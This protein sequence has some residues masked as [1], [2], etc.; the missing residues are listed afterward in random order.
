[1]KPHHRKCKEAKFLSGFDQLLLEKERCIYVFKAKF[2][3]V[4]VVVYALI[5]SDKLIRKSSSTIFCKPIP[6][7]ASK[8]F[9][10]RRLFSS[11]AR[12][13]VYVAFHA[14]VDRSIRIVIPA[15]MRAPLCDGRRPIKLIHTVMMTLAG[16]STAP[17]ITWIK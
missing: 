6:N 2:L 9:P 10:R 17:K 8:L 12:T 11:D 5:K 14:T 7:L 1:M 16:M 15:T 3:W 13:A 4:I